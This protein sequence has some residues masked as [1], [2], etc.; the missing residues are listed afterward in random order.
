MH[1]RSTSSRPKR[2]RSAP[3][4]AGALTRRA[5]KLAQSDLMS[6]YQFALTSDEIAAVADISRLSRDNTGKLLGYQRQEV[7]KHV[8]D[9][10]EYLDSEAPL[11]PHPLI[12]AFSSKVVFTGS[13]GLWVNDGVSTAGTISIPLPRNCEAKPGWLVDGQQRALALSRSRRRNF[14]VPVCAFITD[15]VELQRD[16]FLRVNN[17]R[18][19]PRG[20]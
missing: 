4:S 18:P 17:T 7:R 5:T 16:Q 19:L 13:R 2:T 12:I 10:T 3:L 14:P 15:N 11:F 6:L 9:I 1:Q 20:L 8:A